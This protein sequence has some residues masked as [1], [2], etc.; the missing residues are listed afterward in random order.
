M[1]PGVIG[2]SLAPL[3]DDRRYVE[4]LIAAVRIEAEP[5]F[6]CCVTMNDDA[7]TYEV[8]EYIRSRIQPLISVEYPDMDEEQGRAGPFVDVVDEVPVHVLESAG[9]RELRPGEPVGSVR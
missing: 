9:E 5:D 8:P 1:S 6:R 2:A 7:S 4:S 3:L